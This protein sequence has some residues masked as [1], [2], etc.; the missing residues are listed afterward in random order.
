ME[1]NLFP[2]QYSHLEE[3][4]FS[5]TKQTASLEKIKSFH[6]GTSSHHLNLKK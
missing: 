4:K 5:D 3:T 1:L 2:N 6:E